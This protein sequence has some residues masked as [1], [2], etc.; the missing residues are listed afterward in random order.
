MSESAR[1]VIS[2]DGLLQVEFDQYEMRMSHWVYSPRI[3]N[4]KTRK[5][6]LDLW[7]TQW[8]A[9]VSFENNGEV[10]LSL[11]HYPG[12]IPGFTVHIDPQADTFYF[13]DQPDR[14]ERLSG[15]RSNL[16]QRYLERRRSHDALH[17]PSPPATLA[18]RLSKLWHP[19]QL[20]IL[21]T[22]SLLFLIGG[23][24]WVLSGEG[25]IMGWF[26]VI[27]ALGVLALYVKDMKELL[28]S[29]K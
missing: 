23:V 1:N 5:I 14:S 8:D 29:K 19:I 16:E 24:W 13:M 26:V 11:R 4:V 28:R 6:L 21:I 9:E 12:D 22:L 20:L 3:T 10:A 27:G 25:G 18:T 17:Q 2:P 15:L 7:G